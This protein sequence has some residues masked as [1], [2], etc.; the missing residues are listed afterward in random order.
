MISVNLHSVIVLIGPTNSGKTWFANNHLI[1][2]I[3]EQDKKNIINIGYISSD[4]IRRDLLGNEYDKHDERMIQVSSVTFD[5]IYFDLEQYIKFPVKK[6][7]VI[8]DTT[9][10]SEDFRDNILNICNKHNYVMDIILFDYKNKDEFF[11]FSNNS[12]TAKIVWSHIKKI[13]NFYACKKKYNKSFTIKKHSSTTEYQVLIEKYNDYCACIDKSNDEI[14]YLVIGDIHGCIDEFKE[15]LLLNNFEIDENDIIKRTE[16]TK[17]VKII[18]AGDYVDK[19]PI[20]KIIETIEFIHKNLFTELLIII[21]GNHEV[22]NYKMLVNKELNNQD[23]EY[24]NTYFGIKDNSDIEFKFLEIYTNSIPF[25]YISKSYGMYYMTHC[26][27]ESRYIGKLDNRSVKRQNYTA[28]DKER[29]TSE[30]ILSFVDSSSFNW[31]KH[32]FGHAAIKEVYCGRKHKNNFMGV[33]TGCVYGNKLSAYKICSNQY[34]LKN[35]S[36]VNFKNTFEPHQMTLEILKPNNENSN[37]YENNNNNEKVIPMNEEIQKRVNNIIKCNINT[38]SGTVCPADKEENIFESLRCGA[39]YFLK[40]K[41]NKICAQPKYMGSRCQVYLFPNNLEKSYAVS[42]NGYTIKN[43]N[44]SSKMQIFVTLF[45]RLK[46]FINKHDL[47]LLI[48]D[49]EL[50][51]WNAMG[52]GLINDRFIVIEDG[53]RSENN[54]LRNAGFENRLSSL[55]EEYNNSEY[56]EDSGK[57]N[58]EE[59]YKKYEK[60]K[61]YSFKYIEED[62]NKYPTLEEERELIKTYSKQMDYYARNPCDI[63]Y[64]PFGLL[65]IVNKNKQEFIM[66]TTNRF[67]ID[68]LNLSQSE[69]FRLISDQTTDECLVVDFEKENWFEE[70]NNFYNKMTSDN[71]MEGLVLKAEYFDKT[72]ANFIKVRNKDYLSIIYGYTFNHPNIQKKLI[73]KK[74][75]NSK[76]KQSIKEYNLGLKMLEQNYYESKD[77]NTFINCVA[78]F[79]SN[80]KRSDIDPRL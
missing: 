31:P 16:Q 4:S 20:N 46:E 77:N 28:I 75:I 60:N 25:Y 34:D 52:S 79:L 43:I 14:D 65:K 38:I 66:G 29:T 44:K 54:I 3:K 10:F 22:Q 36:S 49:G 40:N 24:Y 12:N 47:E 42:R 56:K 74:S 5:K 35:I 27:C 2:K 45:N 61:A 48:I 51:P 1:P 50:M 26:F 76:L 9:G 18:I 62:N 72:H 8:V 13:K 68:E 57:L 32:F 7:V 58:K 37:Q 17:N 64:K 11:L 55:K 67:D 33:D 73:N 19:A 59:L 21:N 70:L 71:K 39:E 78:T 30:N 80:E 6:E 69:I 53:I 15:L 63:H 23:R 41:I